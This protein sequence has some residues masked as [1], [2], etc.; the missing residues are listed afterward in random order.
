MCGDIQIYNQK[1]PKPYIDMAVGV[2]NEQINPEYKC[3]NCCQNNNPEQLLIESEHYEH[4]DGDE[5]A[6]Q[7][8]QH[9]ARFTETLAHSSHC[10]YRWTIVR[11]RICSNPLI[12]K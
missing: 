10:H 4:I 8:E 9:L 1:S 3:E 5:E 6:G 12:N 11:K 2:C 7:W